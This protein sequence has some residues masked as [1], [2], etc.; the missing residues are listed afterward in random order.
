[1]PRYAMVIDLRRCVGCQACTVACDKEW[2][3]PLGFARTHVQAT[4]IVGTFPKLS[5]GFRVAQ[6]NHCDRPSCVAACPTGATHQSLD[7][8]VHIDR[9]VC[10]GCGYC[11]E[12]CPYDARFINPVTKAADKCD[13]CASRLERGLQ[14]ACVATC[15]AHAKYFGDLEDSNSEIFHMVYE[16]AARRLE[17]PQ[18][19]IGPNVYYM[20]KKQ[21]VELVFERFPPRLPRTPSSGQLWSRVLKPLVMAAVGAAFF[22][23]AVAFF[24]Q[25]ATGEPEQHEQE[26]R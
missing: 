14:P 10:I 16:Q 25:L 4:G 13:F 12:A 9:G 3:V 2:D 17:T 7:G 20:G 11:V 6:C 15:T 8:I 22:G 5:S 19:V 1:M 18:V 24:Y 26:K 21:D 23:Q